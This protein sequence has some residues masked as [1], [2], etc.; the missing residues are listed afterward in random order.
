MHTV[1]TSLQFGVKESA[2]KARMT[3]TNFFLWIIELRKSDNCAKYLR[4]DMRPPGPRPVSK[5]FT[6]KPFKAKVDAQTA[7]ATVNQKTTDL[8]FRETNNT[9]FQLDLKFSYLPEQ[10]SSNFFE[11]RHQIEAIMPFQKSALILIKK[12]LHIMQP[13]SGS[14]KSSHSSPQS[15]RTQELPNQ[16]HGDYYRP[17]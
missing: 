5:I 3:Q 9:G 16:K 14:G 13:K 1:M 7:P 4:W 10:V 2:T 17:I 12:I 6:A 15:T 11:A 8:T